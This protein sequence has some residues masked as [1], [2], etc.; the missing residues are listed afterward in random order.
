MET[1]LLKIICSKD[2][3]IGRYKEV[4]DMLMGKMQRVENRNNE[5]SKELESVRWQIQGLKK[6]VKRAA[7]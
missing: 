4:I 6:K 5:L 1:K 2:E 3:E 7:P